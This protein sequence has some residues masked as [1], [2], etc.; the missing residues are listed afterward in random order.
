MLP[1]TRMV[2]AVIHWHR[3][4]QERDETDDLVPFAEPPGGAQAGG[5][6]SLPAQAGGSRS[7]PAQAGG[8]RSLPAQAGGSRSLP[9]QPA[10]SRPA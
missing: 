5:S 10:A 3:G 1:L 7:L 8:S 6:R 9:A 2:W 4:A